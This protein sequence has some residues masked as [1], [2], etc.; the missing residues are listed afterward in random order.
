MLLILL[1]WQGPI[2]VC[3]AHATLKAT[4]LP[5]PELASH[6]IAD[7]SFAD[8]SG[9][10]FIDWHWHWIM[11]DELLTKHSESGTNPI[12]DEQ[13]SLS[14]LRPIMQIESPTLEQGT[15]VCF[16]E[17]VCDYV[18]IWHRQNLRRQDLPTSFLMTFASDLSLPERLSVYRC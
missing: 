14:E 9:D 1:A 3:H 5:S 16:L 2:P 18:D 7:H 6:L 8:I 17:V 10:D 12:S 13:S 4:E 15:T 11:P